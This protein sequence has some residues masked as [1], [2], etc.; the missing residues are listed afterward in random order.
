MSELTCAEFVE[1]VTAYLE[2]GLPADVEARFVEHLAACE[3]C[4][5]YL[6]QFRETIRR[7]GSLPVE[8]L[9]APARD[10]L[11]TALREWPRTDGDPNGHDSGPG[12]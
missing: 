5:R 2:H 6:D 1:L 10:R 12:L 8:S 3:G 11:L 4:E 7:L 9:P